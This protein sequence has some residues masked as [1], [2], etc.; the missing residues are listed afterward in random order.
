MHVE[1]VVFNRYEQDK[2]ALLIKR[3]YR[4]IVPY[5]IRN[6]IFLRKKGREFRE[7]I[8]D[9]N[10]DGTM[11]RHFRSIEIETINRCNGIC[12]F[13]PVNRNSDKRKP[14]RMEEGLLE[15][16]LDDLKA[17]N[18]SGK[19]S[20]FSNNEPFLD[21]RM[22]VLLQ[23]AK[24]KLPDARLCL[25]TNGTLLHIDMFK[26]CMV[27]LDEFVIDNYND[28][29]ELNDISKDI[30]LF[31]KTDKGKEILEKKK[32]QI[33]LRKINE[34]LTTRGG[35][36]PN[37]RKRKSLNIG[38]TL[39]FSQMIVRPDGKLSL[40]CNDAYG[41]MTLGDL[42]K[43]NIMSAWNGNKYKELRKQMMDQGRK[44]SPLC[45]YCDAVY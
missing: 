3:L 5:P 13:C 14:L 30:L 41:E 28:K 35:N 29:L 22:P 9:C 12:P 18:Y 32:I 27:Y 23:K 10:R 36:S 8:R 17:E 6:N 4:D 42:S 20:L 26:E 19:I 11:G 39:P 38:C 2:D 33:H 44:C 37:N 43:T 1:E 34:V 15:K 40:C 7:V 25:Y 16:I 24:E 45:L 31:L 21:Q